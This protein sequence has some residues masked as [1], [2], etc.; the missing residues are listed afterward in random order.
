M[1]D[2]DTFWHGSAFTRHWGAADTGEAAPDAEIAP[3]LPQ[4]DP[5]IA[6]FWRRFG[7]AS[8]GAGFLVVD[9]PSAL[10]QL[11]ATWQLPPHGVPLLRTAWGHLFLMRGESTFMLDPLYGGVRDLGCDA[12]TVLDA[13]LVTEDWLN[14]ELLCDVYRAATR[15]IGRT[16]AAQECVTFVPAL[17]L[18]GE[19]HERHVEIRDLAT[20][21]DFLAQT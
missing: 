12:V 18:G 9:R 20:T 10:L 5:L 4:V 14:Q 21:L 2:A 1:T 19:L 16:P 13:L 6:A 7:W 17:S 11:Y 8:F 3:Y 15:R